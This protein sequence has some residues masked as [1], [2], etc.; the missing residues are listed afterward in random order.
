MA[1]RVYIPIDKSAAGRQKQK[2]DAIE[3][4]Q[5]ERYSTPIYE[6]GQITDLVYRSD[7]PLEVADIER[8]IIVQQHSFD[9]MKRIG[10][11][12]SDT[13]TSFNQ[14]H[15]S[16]TSYTIGVRK[17][18]SNLS[19]LKVGDIVEIEIVSNEIT[20]R[21]NID[22][23]YRSTLQDTENFWSYIEGN[24]YPIVETFK[25]VQNTLSKTFFPDDTSEPEELNE[26]VLNTRKTVP[27]YK[28]GK[29]IGDIEVVTLEGKEVEINTAKKYLEMKKA[30]KRERVY[31]GIT[32]GYRSMESQTKIYNSRY[33]PDYQG[34]GT[35]RNKGEYSSGTFDKATRI[36]NN[37]GVAAYPGC[38]N[39]QNGKALDLW[40]SNRNVA[41]LRAN[42]SRFGFFNTVRSENWHWEYLG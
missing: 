26:E 22:G 15:E 31:L 33:E 20:K 32:S 30:A 39:H 1:S 17:N 7:D 9:E 8:K 27:A 4:L 12:P 3:R 41:W 13:E 29:L 11:A 34:T 14:G 35:C 18:S 2:H 38:S 24:A 5:K 37:K 16:I 28:G 21:N 23:F 42:A 19:T 36:D 40:N 10:L 6:I 25:G